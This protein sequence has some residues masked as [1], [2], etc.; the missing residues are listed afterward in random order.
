[1]RFLVLALLN[2]FHLRFVGL[3]LSL[4]V[5]DMLIFMKLL[6]NELVGRHACVWVYLE[7]SL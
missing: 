4:L 2:L 3:L 1:M 5:K 7:G 6:D